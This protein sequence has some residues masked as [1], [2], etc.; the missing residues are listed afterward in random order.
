MSGVILP[1]IRRV[2]IRNFQ[3]LFAEGILN[4][5]LPD[6]PFLL[7]GGNGLGKTTTL[8]TIVFALAGEADP[9]I[10]EKTEFQWGASYFKAR[11]N[12]AAEAEIEVEFSLAD[13]LISI[14]RHLNSKSVRSAKIGDADWIHDSALAG[15]AYEKEVCQAGGYENFE[16]FRYLV[17]RLS[18]VAENR[19]SL[20][21][22]QAAQLRVVMTVCG[23]AAMEREF[24]LLRASLKETDSELRHTN[25]DIGRLEEHLSRI[26][27][28][29][30]GKTIKSEDGRRDSVIHAVEYATCL[31]AELRPIEKERIKLRKQLAGARQELAALNQYLEAS[32]S[33]LSQAEDAFV[34][35][36]L[37][38]MENSAAALALHKLIVHERC[39]YCTQ[40]AAE[41]AKRARDAVTAGLCP[42]CGQ[43]HSVDASVAELRKL[44]DDISKK[45]AR[46]DELQ[47]VVNAIEEEEARLI[48]R[49]VT[50][51]DKLNLLVTK[52]PRVQFAEVLGIV[53]SDPEELRTRLRTTKAHYARLEVRKRNL[54]VEL[55]QKYEEFSK[56]CARRLAQLAALAAEYGAKF[57]GDKCEFVMTPS[58]ERLSPFSF[59]VPQFAEKKRE[60]PESCSE[61]ERFFLDIAFRMATVTFSG[62]LSKSRST[63]ICET[64]EN[65]LDLAYTDN[66]AA[67]FHKFSVDKFSILLTANLQLGGVAK[68]LLRPYPKGEKKHRCVNLIEKCELSD[69]QAKKRSQFMRIYRQIVG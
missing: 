36:T 2:R 11:L 9:R 46:Q 60:L 58:R 39:P 20:V 10:E 42:I 4:F 66:V 1:Q 69:V 65:A 18:Y 32:Q 54:Q 68:P 31:E 26:E 8:Q 24:R 28:K 40:K 50:I 47:L 14:R 53:G 21:W 41:L 44:R 45:T 43:N 63:F 29:E 25:V 35:G 62:L 19:Q 6:G 22:D 38:G 23:D 57:L 56:F 13:S 55:S 3:P 16:D 67:M 30:K 34:L 59:F 5:E 51:K 64:P 12:D 15:N 61:S 33:R 27:P 48:S 49:E 17:H 37:R 7:L 52:L